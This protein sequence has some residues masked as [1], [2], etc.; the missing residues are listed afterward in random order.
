MR[1]L[2]IPIRRF[3]QRTRT[4]D[5][6]RRLDMFANLI[7]TK[8]GLPKHRDV[9]ERLCELATGHRFV[10]SDTR[11]RIQ[12]GCFEPNHNWKIITAVCLLLASCGVSGAEDAYALLGKH[13]KDPDVEA[14]T[15]AGL[16]HCFVDAAGQVACPLLGVNLALDG[17]AIIKQVTFYPNAMGAYRPY[18]GPLPFGL[19][20]GDTRAMVVSKLGRPDKSLTDTDLYTLRSPRVS[21]TYYSNTSPQAGLIHKLTV[22]RGN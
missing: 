14:F 1:L 13:L 12:R 18:A 20:R 8:T 2:P 22:F 3:E 16:K 5:K 9:Y 19:A 4:P 6:R 7:G 15:G 11:L 17:N 10:Q 21:V